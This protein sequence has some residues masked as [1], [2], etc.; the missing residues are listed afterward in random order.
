[1]PADAAGLL[2]LLRKSGL[3][4]TPA[5]LSAE[6]DPSLPTGADALAAA[7]VGRG[8]LTEWQA[9]RLLAGEHAGF[10]LG[11]YRL[12]G[13][14]GQGG[15]GT[16][17][18]AEHLRLKRRVA[19]KVFQGSGDGALARFQREGRAAARLDH[20]A[21]V[22]VLDSGCDGG[23]FWLAMELV[24]G[25]TLDAVLKERGK[26]PVAEAVGIA[27]HVASALGHASARG[28]VHRDIKPGNIM[29]AADGAAKVLDMGLARLADDPDSDLT[30][31][32]DDGAVLGT[33]DYIAP[34]QA[35]GLAVDVRADLYSLGATLYALLAGHPPFIVSNISQKLMAHQL[36]DAPP[37]KG[38]PPELAAIVARLLRKT[39]EHRFQTPAALVAALAP[40]TDAL[41][42]AERAP[43]RPWLLAAA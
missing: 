22:R 14:L 12:L 27:L 34:E 18:L 32:L 1:M 36:R 40:F 10:S 15:M 7:L 21:I 19:L 3:L 30:R 31:R 20:P 28:V 17:Y 8:L 43:R 2:E 35:L 26:L 23:R 29:L 41:P 5:L 42:L 6:G 4:D 39:P 25:R 33:A 11:P 16:V 37:L 38:A 24:E 9:A 13:E